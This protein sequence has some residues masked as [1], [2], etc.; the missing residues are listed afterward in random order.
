[1]DLRVGI[2]TFHSQS[3]YGGVLQAIALQNFLIQ[4][5]CDVKI[6][7]RWMMPK[8]GC[9]NGVLVARSFR[10]WFCF[11]VRA[12]FGFG[13]VRDLIRCLRTKNFI[14]RHLKLTDYCFYD[15][16]EAPKDL[17]VDVIVVGSDQ[18]W[19]RHFWDPHPY[20]MIGAPEIPAIS[21][22]ASMGMHA[23]PSDLVPAFK[24]GIPKFSAISV[25]ER[26]AGS[27]VAPYFSKRIQHVVDPTLLI[28]RSFW[29]RCADRVE[30]RIG[31]ESKK[32]LVC[33]L[34]HT[35]LQECVKALELFGH[36]KD[37]EVVF[38]SGSPCRLMP[39]ELLPL[40]KACCLP[41]KMIFSSIRY[42]PMIMPD[43]FVS[44]I[45]SADWVITDSFHGLMFSLIYRKDVRI[46]RPTS[47]M[48]ANM[49]ARISEIV[50]DFIVG[51][52]FAC[53]IHTAVDSL[54]RGPSISYRTKEIEMRR[55][56]SAEWLREAL[57]SAL[58]E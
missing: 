18:V 43:E 36:K 33:Y 42:R 1:M 10:T 32:K 17:G 38:L 5:G 16:N 56:S 9:L 28:D 12:L 30:R 49:S 29:D 25:R 46:L 31:S 53:T 3:S 51:N 13:D 21:Y 34:L 35:E 37:C 47:S 27:L 44:E 11:L 41:I 40:L 6:I 23:I 54:C 22:A 19:G 52:P 14:H 20:L 4:L 57:K 50:E 55:S 8:N 7:D 39:R 26:E 2:L 48:S 58:R 15:W 24:T 45:R